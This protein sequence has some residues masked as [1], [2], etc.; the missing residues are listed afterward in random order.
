[1][2][3]AGGQRRKFF[4]SFFQCSLFSSPV[5]LL[6]SFYT[7]KKKKI[8]GRAISNYPNFQMGVACVCTHEPCFERVI[9]GIQSTCLQSN[10]WRG[11]GYFPFLKLPLT[12]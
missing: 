12:D 4:F 6:L 2:L 8:Q 3:K 1:M 9:G 7:R 5:S 11:C 10:F